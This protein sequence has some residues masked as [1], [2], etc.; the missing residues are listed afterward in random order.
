MR[1]GYGCIV[2]FAYI[3]IMNNAQTMQAHDTTPAR[4]VHKCK[5]RNGNNRRS[6]CKAKADA[7]HGAYAK[8]IER[9]D[10]Q[11]EARKKR[12]KKTSWKF[13]GKV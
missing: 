4:L 5:T 12:R 7:L 1:F 6:E 3:Y 10:A 9:A 8:R 13:A 2:F 11:R